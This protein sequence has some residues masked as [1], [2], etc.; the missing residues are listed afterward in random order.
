MAQHKVLT[1]YIYMKPEVYLTQ[2][3]PVTKISILAGIHD[4]SVTDVEEHRVWKHAIEISCSSNSSDAD[5]V[6]IRVKYFCLFWNYTN[7]FLLTVR[8]V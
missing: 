7:Y 6:L 1:S 2:K 8:V 5:L 3:E 4:T